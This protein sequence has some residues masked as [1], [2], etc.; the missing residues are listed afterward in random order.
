MKPADRDGVAT[1]DLAFVQAYTDRHG[2]RRHYFRRKGFRAALPGTPG[3]PEFMTA[4]QAAM[5]RE[6]P[7]VA[8]EKSGTLGRLI[9]DY[10]ASANFAN[11][12]PR[13][14]KSYRSVLEA[15]G[16]KHG[17]RAVRDMPRANARKII[18]EIGA[19][20]PGL[21][22]L[23]RAVLRQLMAYAVSMN[24]RDDNPF[25]GIAP[26]KLGTR[27][28]W[29]DAE[30]HTYEA[31][32]PLGTRERLA[33]SL[34]L[35]TGQRVGDVSAMKRADIVD[36]VIFVKQ[37]KTGAELYIPVHPQLRAVIKAGPKQGLTIIGDSAGRP[38]TRDALTQLIKT[39]AGAA[40]LPARC[41][42]HGLRKA[43]LRTLA[44]RG[45]TAKEISAI[46]GHAS[47]KEIE[48]YTHAAD[49]KILASAA[50]GKL[51]KRTKRK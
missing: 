25:T 2:R 21:A 6:T 49:Q 10:Y 8:K 18:E 38:I 26:Y 12:K 19:T 20:R 47:L 4:Y 22:N 46:S 23:A 51:D 27:H 40:G 16:E 1:I 7:P 15:V 50:V 14:K 37:E 24:L 39:A 41:L 32:W 48:R 3:S 43:L 35:Y 5:A 17:H 31:R 36:N 13:S 42:P 45:A 9:K 30:L 44:E 28:T 34:L 33:Y 29:T 11:L